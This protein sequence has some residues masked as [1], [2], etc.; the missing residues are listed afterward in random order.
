MLCVVCV[1]VSA[2]ITIPQTVELKPVFAGG[3]GYEL[4]LSSLLPNGA[5]KTTWV[6][7]DPPVADA[8]GKHRASDGTVIE[9]PASVTMH[10]VEVAGNV[11]GQKLVVAPKKDD[12]RLE[13]Y[14]FELQ[15]TDTHANKVTIRFSI[16]VK[17]FG[18]DESKVK[19]LT[20]SVVSV[21]P[22][23]EVEPLPAIPVQPPFVLASSTADEETIELAQEYSGGDPGAFS[24]EPDTSKANVDVLTKLIAGT[25]GSDKNAVETPVDKEA[26]TKFKAGDYLLM[27]V[28]KWNDQ[29]KVDQKIEPSRELWALFQGKDN[30]ADPM[31]VEW[32]PQPDVTNNKT[33][34][35]R[36]FGSK[37]VVVLLIHLHTPPTWDVKYKVEINQR[38]PTPIQN[39][40]T[41]AAAI[42]GGGLR[43]P[44]QPKDIWGARLML[45]RY[46]ASDL[47]VKV[48]TITANSSK[49]EQA[50]D[51]SKK[52]LN[53]G[54]YRWDVSVGLPIKSIREL[55][56]KT[57][58]NNRV[59]TSA[60]ER[61]SVYG[62]LNIFLKKADLSSEDFLS[63]PHLVFGVPLAS[64][65]LQHPFAGLGYG[66]YKTPIKFNFFAGVVFNREMVPR[67]LNVGNSATSDQLE[68]DLRARWVR[69]FMFG[70]NIPISQIKD[71]IK[72]K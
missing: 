15:G 53:E 1:G 38:M 56:Y 24:D 10:D 37:R 69:K 72:N 20:G 32:K 34:N 21:A 42:G 19:A 27:H 40:L 65:P 13:P 64:K 58:A 30:A 50:K 8:R 44:D 57:D 45:I 61:Q 46:P 4:P 6:L 7:L 2:D 60:K 51:Y 5:T 33:F 47:V 36:I 25:V 29:Q 16:Q 71:A 70:V 22:A 55:Q 59:T 18:V 12:A 63:L 28:I 66:V 26:V 17:P 11:T 14:F 23:R 52:Y 62:F 49:V 68:S 48:T 3:E 35:T 54:R 67:T 41:L 39:V 31:H 43:K 9:K